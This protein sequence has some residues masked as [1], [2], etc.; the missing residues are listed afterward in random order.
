MPG[1]GRGMPDSDR[2]QCLYLCP[3][4]WTYTRNLTL[5]EQTDSSIYI[6]SKLEHAAESS[7]CP[8]LLLAWAS[9]FLFGFWAAGFA[10]ARYNI[11]GCSS[12]IGK[13]VRVM[14]SIWKEAIKIDSFV[15]PAADQLLQSCGI[16]SENSWINISKQAIIFN[17]WI[18][19]CREIAPIPHDCN[20]ID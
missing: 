1:S 8:N 13:T 7:V 18:K 12:D 15:G 4:A 9:G 2:K 19:H 16:R 11:A 6:F 5:R 14:G 17:L 10:Q 3:H 20:R